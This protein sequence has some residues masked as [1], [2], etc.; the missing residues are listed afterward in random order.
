MSDYTNYHKMLAELRATNSGKD[1]TAILAR[2][3]VDPNI[4]KLLQL[5]YDPYRPYYVGEGKMSAMC[6]SGLK[7]KLTGEWD[8]NIE[9]LTRATDRLTQRTVSGNLALE[10]IQDLLQQHSPDT[11][12]EIVRILLKNIA[13]GVTAKTINAGSTAAGLGAIIPVYSIQLAHPVGNRITSLEYPLWV[14]YKYDGERS[15]FESH[16]T[17]RTGEYVAYSRE[18]RVQEANLEIWKDEMAAVAQYFDVDSIVLDA[19]TIDTSFKGVA[20]GKGKDAD[21]SGRKLVIF[22]ILTGEEWRGKT[23][24]L[25][26]SQRTA[27]IADLINCA[28]LTRLMMPVGKLVNNL[29]ELTEFYEEAIAAGLEG[30]MIKTLDG[31]YE[32]KRS[33]SWM[34]HK[35]AET[36]DGVITSLNPGKPGGKWEGRYGSYTVE[37][38]LEDGTPFRVNVGSGLPQSVLED[39]NQNPDKY[40]H[41]HVE[42]KYDIP[43][44]AD[45]SSIASLRFPRHKKMR[46]DKD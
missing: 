41:H 31:R 19:E 35:P 27:A 28:G 13:A 4:M 8:H 25:P 18:G 40:L 12:A 11:A 24:A 39:I 5:A 45:D 36:A 23:C 44:F 42:L 29:Q 6:N 14:E 33:W 34:K 10:H 32:Y 15:V 21:K 17:A 7:P 9:V 46:P 26:Q 1:K 16:Y 20:K 38:K 2:Y 43:S 22:D 30:I 37:G 3:I